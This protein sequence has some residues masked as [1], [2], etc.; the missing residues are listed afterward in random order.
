M[1]DANRIDL[2]VLFW[3]AF[4]LAFFVIACAW[5]LSVAS[6]TL[7][8]GSKHV[9]MQPPRMISRLVLTAVGAIGVLA[10]ASFVGTVLKQVSGAEFVFLGGAL[11]GLIVSFAAFPWSNRS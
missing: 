8:I 3:V 10:A 11:V 6:G 2:L 9:N 7:T 5:R 1:T 4:S